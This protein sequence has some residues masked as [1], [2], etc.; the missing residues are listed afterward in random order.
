M[1]PG[2][3][4]QTV[5]A[6]SNGSG[7]TVAGTYLLST[8]DTRTKP[9]VIF[10]YKGDELLGKLPAEEISITSKPPK[11][12]GLY[13]VRPQPDDDDDAVNV[14][15]QRCWA[16]EHI[17]LYFDEGYMIPFNS[18]PFRAL[19]TQGRS[20]KIERI[21]LTQRPVKLDRFTFSEAT[22]FFIFRLTDTRDKKTVKT[23]VPVDLDERLPPFHCHFY[24]VRE[25]EL[26]IMRPV[27]SEDVILERFYARQAKGRRV[28]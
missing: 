8:K 14:F 16:Q 24:G 11:K 28:I 13:I 25:D 27:P 9:Y 20:K 15:L 21:I 4:D 17:G 10:D 3:T 12:S 18:R 26:Q 5:F 7:K 19:L 23:M 6:G 2:P 22:Y 1:W